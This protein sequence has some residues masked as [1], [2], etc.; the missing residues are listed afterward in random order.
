MS[1][2]TGGCTAET[3][4]NTDCMD[5]TVGSG[6]DIDELEC[7][8]TGCAF[9]ADSGTPAGV[10]CGH[11]GISTDETTTTSALAGSGDV[12]DALD[13][14]YIACE[15]TNAGPENTG[16][17]CAATGTCTEG[18]TTTITCTDGRVGHGEATGALVCIYTVCASCI[19]ITKVI[20]AACELT[21]GFIVAIITTSQQGGRGADTA[22]SDVTSTACES[23]GGGLEPLGSRFANTGILCGEIITTTI[24]T[25]GHD[26]SGAVTAA[27]VYTG[28]GF[29]PCTGIIKGI[30]AVSARTGISG[31]GTIIT[32]P[33]DG[34]GE[35]TV[36]SAI[37]C[38]GNV[39]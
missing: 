10:M 35:P 28:T 16:V 22:V 8:S 12:T 36:A 13:V 4:S 17:R 9:C 2:A 33:V 11:T 14:I 20:G 19:A 30:G 23:S 37:T 26:G 31:V 3:I 24:C 15:L 18:T 38:T 27:L 21:G 34:T 7:T 29:V 6:V 39:S 5:T 32:S 1:E 25:V